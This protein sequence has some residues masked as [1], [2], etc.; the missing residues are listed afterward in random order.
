[1]TKVCAIAIAAATLLPCAAV[2]D[3]MPSRG[4][5]P[6]YYDWS[7]IYVGG[8]LGGAWSNTEWTWELPPLVASQRASIDSTS[9]IGGGQVGV[10]KQWG[11]VVTGIEVSYSG[12]DERGSTVINFEG[13]D[14]TFRAHFDDLL[15]V[16]ARL[17]YAQD[18]WLGYVKG[19]YASSS[20]VKLDIFRTI[21]GLHQT[22]SSEQMGGYTVGAG[23]DYAITKSISLG[24]EYNYVRLGSDD[25]SNVNIPPT[26]TSNH[27][28]ID[29]DVSTVWARL[30]YKFDWNRE[31][32]P[33]K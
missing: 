15:L 27:R 13:F 14:R 31:Y 26:I 32:V 33:L 18:R 6:T 9:F 5:L 28:D 25:V 30:N 8:H 1:M 21:D 24:V 19:G 12:L 3:G 11:N 2:A 17:G 20:D 16:T 10:Q 7:G 22:S 4:Y 23:L 29:V